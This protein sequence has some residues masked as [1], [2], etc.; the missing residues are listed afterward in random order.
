MTLDIQEFVRRFRLHILPERFTKIRHYGLL[1]NRGRQQR[2]AQARALFPKAAAAT[3]ASA[4]SPA[5]QPVCCPPPTCPHCKGTT[6]KLLRI[7]LPSG[8]SKPPLN[9]SS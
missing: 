5:A 1:A 4:T 3:P 2:L 9:D 6:L 7:I 8:S